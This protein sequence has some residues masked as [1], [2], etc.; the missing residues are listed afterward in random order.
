M[1]TK[2]FSALMIAVLVA[3]LSLSSC[4][5]M[6]KEEKEQN[7]KDSLSKAIIEREQTNGVIKLS[8]ETLYGLNEIYKKLRKCEPG[9]SIG[10]VPVEF[11]GE[12]IFVEY[13]LGRLGHEFGTYNRSKFEFSADSKS[14]TLMINCI[15]DVKVDSF[16][17]TKSRLFKDCKDYSLSGPKSVFV[18]KTYDTSGVII[19]EHWEPFAGQKINGIEYP[20]YTIK[21]E[22]NSGN[23]HEIL[24]TFDMESL[25]DVT[26]GAFKKTTK[27]RP[28]RFEDEL[29]SIGGSPENFFKKA[30]IAFNN[31][32]KK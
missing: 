7:S 2:T 8:K 23:F 25:I 27:V 29:L 18:S 28:A 24:T 13:L 30:I 14:K 19:K 31:A 9:D 1:K 32:Y 15:S 20:D 4:H 12:T 16:L 10:G 26:K 3:L 17:R 21:Y 6:T 22:R 11:L 5:K